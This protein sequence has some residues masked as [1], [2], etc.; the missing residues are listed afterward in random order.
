MATHNQLGKFGEETAVN[1][2]IKNGYQIQHRNW[3][4]R[5]Y[6]IDIIAIQ[7]NQLVFIEVK[8]RTPNPDFSPEDSLTRSKQKQLI[9]GAHHYITQNGWQQ[10][11]R[12]DVIKVFI[13]NRKTQIEHIENAIIPTW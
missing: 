10:E 1:Y 7:N 3:R 12:I 13:A 9:E 5:K 2:L 8:T 4:Y 11:A 6:E